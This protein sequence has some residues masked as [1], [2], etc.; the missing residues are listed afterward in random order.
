MKMMT[1]LL[2]AAS[3]GGVIYLI[4]EW[5]PRVL[6]FGTFLLIMI[7]LFWYIISRFME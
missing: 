2:I 6:L 1:P 3:A 4:M 5:N 7:G